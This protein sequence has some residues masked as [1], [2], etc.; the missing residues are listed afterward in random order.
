MPRNNALIKGTR[1]WTSSFH[2]AKTHQETVLVKPG[3]TIQEPNHADT[4]LPTSR[5]IRNKC[6]FFI[7]SLSV[8]NKYSSSPDGG[9]DSREC[10][11]SETCVDP[12][13]STDLRVPNSLIRDKILPWKELLAKK[14]CQVNKKS[15]TG[16]ATSVCRLFISLWRYKLVVAG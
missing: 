9:G 4:I 3:G 8:Y 5:T 11:M 16:N 13:Q 15:R 1:E 2:Y 6:L 14:Y 10:T 7:L 12:C